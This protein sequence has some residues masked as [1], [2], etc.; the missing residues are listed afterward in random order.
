MV[1][2]VRIFLILVI[3]FSPSLCL[4]AEAPSSNILTFTEFYRKVLA[5][6]PKLK[7]ESANINLA[8]SR[9]M[10]AAASALP[11]L[12]GSSSVTFSSDPVF[13]FGSLLREN[14]FSQDNFEISKLNN[15]SP[16]TSYNLSLEGSVPIFDA[17][18]AISRVRSAKL[19]IESARFEAEF[20][21]MEAFLVASEAYLRALAIDKLLVT[22][23]KINKDCEEDV[24]QIEGLSEQGLTL[25]AD[26]YA[27]KVIYGNISQFKNK[28]TQEKQTAHTLMNIL[29][30]VDPFMPFEIQGELGGAFYED[31]PLQGWFEEAYKY[32][33]DLSA[34]D[35]TIQSQDIE[36]SREKFTSLPKVNAFGQA[37][38]DTHRLSSSGGQSYTVGV[39]AEIDLF[40]PAHAS[41]IQASKDT[42]RKLQYDKEI[43]KLTISRDVTNEFSHYKIVEENLPVIRKMLGDAKEAVRLTMP[44]YQE[45]RKSIA[46]LLQIRNSYLN[47]SKEYYTLA[48]DSSASWT[49]LLFLTGQL[50]EARLIELA[51][52]II[53][54]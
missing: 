15:P 3:L 34:I 14:A 54:E 11:R 28:L 29:M 4:A 26:F 42:L 47:V 23:V 50:D 2:S 49:R 12:Q 39:K 25:G 48:I 38:E 19:H 5:Y 13:V 36:V 18:Q 8:I 41:R 46:E 7:R 43:L 32:R 21:K 27:A 52:R 35:K 31:K 30:G 51:K 45:G 9:K 6:Y 53:H 16:H 44:L 37:R 33:P 24:L 22:V 40:D 20:T 17:F 1:R 10:L